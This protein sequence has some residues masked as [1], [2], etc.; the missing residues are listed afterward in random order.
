MKK[1]IILLFTVFLLVGSLPAQ[2]TDVKKLEQQ[3]SQ[4][5]AAAQFNL[6]VAYANGR[7]VPQDDVQ[8][9]KWYR[10]AADQ[11]NASAQYNLG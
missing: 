1:L 10:L 4:G 3:A 8:A 6:G 9:V 2:S 5:L 11:G 7:G